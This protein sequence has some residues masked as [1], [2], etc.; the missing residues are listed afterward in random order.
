MSP[1]PDAPA[2]PLD[3]SGS[4]DPP[5]EH[6]DTPIAPFD[7]RNEAHDLCLCEEHRDA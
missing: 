5:E 2:P 3:A 7:P 4:F 6:D 1:S